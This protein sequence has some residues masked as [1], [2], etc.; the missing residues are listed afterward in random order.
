MKQTIFTLEEEKLIRNLLKKRLVSLEEYGHKAAKDVKVIEEIFKKMDSSWDKFYRPKHKLKITSCINEFLY[1][2][3]EIKEEFLNAPALKFTELSEQDKENLDLFD[4]CYGIL[5]KT[6]HKKSKFRF[7]DIFNKI[8]RIK[9]CEHV[10]LSRIEGNL[11]YKIAFIDNLEVLPWDAASTI[12]IIRDKFQKKSAKDI[13]GFI[14]KFTDVL[15]RKE[16][17]KIVLDNQHS[18][19]WQLIV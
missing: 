1:P 2:Y 10:C 13:T 4:F 17:R 12:D 15:D 5:E 8:R 11:V 7:S 3:R 16:A 19:V 14:N 18:E 9:N 6:G